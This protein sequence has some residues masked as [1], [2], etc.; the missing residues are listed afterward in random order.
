[1]R[2]MLMSLLVRGVSFS[3]AEAKQNPIVRRN[4]GLIRRTNSPTRFQVSRPVLVA[5]ALTRRA[6]I[7]FGMRS[8]VKTSV[9]MTTNAIQAI[10]LWP[11]TRVS[12]I[13]RLARICSMCLRK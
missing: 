4:S 10:K 9:Q 2:A 6:I 7:F 3:A 12:R 1:M 13:G 5:S 8:A 11:A